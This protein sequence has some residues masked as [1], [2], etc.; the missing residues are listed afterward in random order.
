MELNS[1]ELET[2][3]IGDVLKNSRSGA[4]CKVVEISRN[5][6]CVETPEGKKVITISTLKRWYRQV[7]NESLAPVNNESSNEA[8]LSKPQEENAELEP[9]IQTSKQAI[10]HAPNFQKQDPVLAQVRE[11]L[12]NECLNELANCTTGETN[13]YTSLKVSK[14]NFAEIYRGKRRFNIRVMADALTQEQL[15]VCVIAPESY[16]WTLDATFTVLVEDDLEMAMSILK[17]SY[18]YRLRNLPTRGFPKSH[19]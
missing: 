12:I 15:D 5:A 13:S 16:H 2:L 7:I 11:R 8:E 4:E 17:A 10:K 18:A 19:K 14:F 1:I 6:V 3:R 9:P